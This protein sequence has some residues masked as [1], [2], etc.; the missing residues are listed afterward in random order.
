LNPDKLSWE[1]IAAKQKELEEKWRLEPVSFGVNQSLI[2]PFELGI[3]KSG[4]YDTGNL[5][6]IWFRGKMKLD[7]CKNQNISWLLQISM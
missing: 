5:G 2:T 4:I 1:W 3:I 7:C 6:E